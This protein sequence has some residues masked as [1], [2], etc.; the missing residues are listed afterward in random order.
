MACSTPYCILN[1]H[2]YRCCSRLNYL[3]ALGSEPMSKRQARA[4]GCF[5]WRWHLPNNLKLANQRIGRPIGITANLRLLKYGT[6]ERGL[7]KLLRPSALAAADK[8]CDPRDATKG[9]AIRRKSIHAHREWVRFIRSRR[10]I[11]I[12]IWPA[13][14]SKQPGWWI[15]VKL[16]ADGEKKQLLGEW[17][18]LRSTEPIA[19]H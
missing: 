3:L 4:G 18:L 12:L 6:T 17:V 10:G 7:L 14:I 16:D 19:S 15:G 1:L 8:R 13:L 9:R 2:A 11:R 5:V